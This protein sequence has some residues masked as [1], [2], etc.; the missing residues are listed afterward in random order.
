MTKIIEI[1]TNYPIPVFMLIGISIAVVFTIIEETKR[2][3]RKK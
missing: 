3:K 1:V 2:R